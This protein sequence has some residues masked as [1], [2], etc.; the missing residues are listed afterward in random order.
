MNRRQFAKTTAATG[1]GLTIGGTTVSAAEYV[2]SF[3]ADAERVWIGPEYWARPMQDWRLRQGRIECVSGGQGRAVYLLNTQL[4]DAPSPFHISVRLGKLAPKSTDQTKGWAGFRIGI[5]GAVNEYRHNVRHGRTGVE[6]G[7]DAQGRL[8][9]GKYHSDRTSEGKPLDLDD[10]TLLFSAVLAFDRKTYRQ[11][12]LAAVD[13]KTGKVLGQIKRENVPAGQ[14]VGS[15]ALVCSTS[16]GDLQRDPKTGNRENALRFRFSDWKL[17]GGNVSVNPEYVFGPILFSQYSLN[18]GVLKITAQMPPIGRNDC[19][20]VRLEVQGTDGAW[21]PAGEAAIDPLARTAAIRVERWD[22]SRDV[23]YRLVYPFTGT[24]GRRRTHHWTGT[25]RRDPVDEDPLKLAAVG[26]RMDYAFPDLEIV[27]RLKAQDPDMLFFYGDQLYE[28]NEGFG[29]QRGPLQKAT[30]DYL[31]KYYQ[32]GWVFGELMR[33]RPTITIPDDHDVYQGNLWGDGGRKG[34]GV[35]DSGGY[36]MPAEWVNMVQRTQTSHLPD[37]F[38]PK[39]VSQDIGVYYCDFVYGRVSFAVVEDRKFKPGPASVAPGAK[40]RPDHITDANFDPKSIDRP[41]FHLL[42]ERQEEFLRRWAADWRGADMK[43]LLSQSPFAGLA[44]HHGKFDNYLVAD[45]DCNGWPQSGR[46]RAYD[47]LRRCFA[48]HIAGDQHLS[49]LVRHGIE[50]FNDACHSFTAPAAATGYQRWWRPEEPGKNRSPDAPEY[51]GEF[52]DGLGNKIAMLAVANPG[53]TD[54]KNPFSLLYEKAAG[55]G[56]VKMN[57]ADGTYTIE[58]WPIYADPSDPASG[59]QYPG[60][61]RTISMQENY[62]RRPTAYLPIIEVSG[63]KNPVLRIHDELDGSLVY[64][65]RI[66]GAFHRPKVFKAGGSYRIEV[67]EP[68]TERL[69]SLDHVK[70]AATDEE[71]ISVVL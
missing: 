10:L 41:E 64:A 45:L 39:P 30:L 21:Q 18:R 19:Q 9:I 49:T 31:R 28:P 47:I 48:L 43:V 42:G 13:P 5:R 14:L 26:C 46:N 24:D 68:G 57:K 27:E 52:I 20:T 56:I 6:A 15:V 32:H 71:K 23:P 2:G 59:G 29:T 1:L 70:P 65:L 33:D 54:R 35:G 34:E 4:D 17:S 60:W 36:I 12:A 69:K 50:E 22:S 16:S 67:G 8:F 7:V 40:G 38:D 66:R 53:P 58:S 51:T 61:P 3:P 11:L 44:T 63:M 55:Y 25:I 37:P 62:G